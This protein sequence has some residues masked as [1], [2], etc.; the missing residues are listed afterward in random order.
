MKTLHLFLT[1]LTLIVSS[2]ILPAQEVSLYERGA[3][4]LENTMPPSPEPASA[5]K[6]ADVPF[7]HSLGLAEYGIPIYTLEGRELTL[8]IGLHYS[9]G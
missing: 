3:T 4:Y 1:V 7:T 6:F 5:V 2:V 9:S 8:P